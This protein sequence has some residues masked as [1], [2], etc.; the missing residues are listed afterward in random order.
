[1][2]SFASPGKKSL[3][4][5]SSSLG[6]SPTIRVFLADDHPAVRQA[7]R[8]TIEEEKDVDVCGEAASS[9]EAL[10]QI[11]GLAPDVAIVDISLE[12]A[13]GFDLLENL[14]A[15]VPETEALVYS[16]YEEETY[17]MRAINAGASGYLKKSVAPEKI[18]EA[19]RA[20]AKGEIFLSQN[21]SSKALKKVAGR[22]PSKTKGP[23]ELLSDREL[24]VFQML[25]LGYSVRDIQERL[26]LAQKTVETHRRRAR[27]KLGCETLSDLYRRALRWTNSQA[28]LPPEKQ[29]VRS[30]ERHL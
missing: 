3:G 29:R 11:E 2:P 24:E 10:R 5:P 20:V 7:L 25:G 17:A 13:H 12:D 21:M 28:S 30:R 1:M 19:I 26:S 27:K 15:F 9:G 6:A 4:A 18:T 14:Q 8:G 22:A 23:G 16:M